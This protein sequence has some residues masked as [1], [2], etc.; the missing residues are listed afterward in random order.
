MRFFLTLFILLS[1]SHLAHANEDALKGI[2]AENAPP[3]TGYYAPEFCDFEITFPE[4]PVTSRRCVQQS[5][6]C[7][8]IMGF[9]FVYDMQTTVEV[10]A[11]CRPSK[12]ENYNQYNEAVIN[13]V[14][15]SMVK[16]ADIEQ[17][18]LNTQELEDQKVR[19]GSLLG[20]GTYNNQEKI[21]NAQIWVGENSIL[22]IE[23]KMIGKNNQEADEAFAD[24]LASIGVK[25]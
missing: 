19:Q 9:V 6:E 10:T 5:G 21:Y 22:T 14:L 20:T 24:I 7:Y 11:Q 25:N 23:G 16:R 1:F 13:T 4:K 17:Y 8:Q 15:K 18:D 12:P 3:P 2:L